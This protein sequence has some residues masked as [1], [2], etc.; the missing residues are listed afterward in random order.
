MILKNNLYIC[1]A[2]VYDIPYLVDLLK[3]LF[4][5]E[6]DFIFNEH[7]HQ[8][9]L[10][11]LIENLNTLLS[12]AKFEGDIVA[13]ISMQTVI[14]TAM[15][16][17]AGLIEDFVVHDDY[18]NLGIGSHLLTYIKQKAKE[19]NIQRLQLVCD[20]FNDNAKEFYTKKSFKKSN[21]WAWYYFME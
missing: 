4:H 14:S 6:K 8:E 15:G 10:R 11:L 19:N 3:Q 1:E 17:K 2:T 12:I 21:L 7:K 9:G 20:N 16:T 5:I 13:M 18:K